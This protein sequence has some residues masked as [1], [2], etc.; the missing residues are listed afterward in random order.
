M[1]LT[2]KTFEILFRIRSLQQD[3][4]ENLFGCIRGNCGSNTN[5][6][7][8]QFVAGLK[9]AIISNLSHMGTTG[10]C[11]TD[12]NVIINNFDSFLSVSQS[13][14]EKKDSVVTASSSS[15]SYALYF[16][17]DEAINTNNPEIQACA[18]VAGFILKKLPLKDCEICRK[19]FV[20]D[21]IDITHNFVANREYGT[22]SQALNY[23]HKDFIFCV[24]LC[25]SVINNF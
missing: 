16:E 9:A 22:D 13:A 1:H 4:L 20:S 14:Q 25:A 23:A 19:I 7:C 6:T 24:E 8:G 5:P 3:A 18:Y 21:N 11:E 2:L 10:N 12:N 15:T 17:V